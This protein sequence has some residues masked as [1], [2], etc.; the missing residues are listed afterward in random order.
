MEILLK[1]L[2]LLI[3]NNFSNTI[4]I[5]IL[6]FFIQRYYKLR[7]EF[8]SEKNKHYAQ[9]FTNSCRELFELIVEIRNKLQMHPNELISYSTKIKELCIK[10]SLFLNEELIK[11]CH[12]Y[13]DY[14][15]EIHENDCDRNL[16]N[17]DI[18]IKKFKKEF[19]K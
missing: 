18:L 1:E 10:N 14:L 7:D 2:W 8:K 17:E 19:K 6:L 15:L 9:H 11:I 12:N 3:K 4:L 5:G 16:I 13:S